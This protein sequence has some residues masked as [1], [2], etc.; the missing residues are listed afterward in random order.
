[1][2]N[3]EEIITEAIRILEDYNPSSMLSRDRSRFDCIDFLK[4]NFNIDDGSHNKW[5]IE[6]FNRNRAPEDQVSTIKEL[7]EKVDEIFNS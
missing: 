1:M 5:R 2:N 6:Q 3:I 7:E 4:T